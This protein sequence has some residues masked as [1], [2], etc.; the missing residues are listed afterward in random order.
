MERAS[1]II[2]TVCAASKSGFAQ[3][4]ADSDSPVGAY[5][6]IQVSVVVPT[7]GRA[8]LLNRCLEALT[9]QHFEPTAYEIIIVDDG[10][11]QDT[12]NIVA[13]WTART[14]QKRLD[15]FYIANHGPH[16]PA[17]ARNRG[18]RAARAPIIAFTDDDTVPTA[19]WLKNGLAQFAHDVD[20]ISGR[21][22]MPVSGT[23]TDYERD[24]QHLETAEFVTANCFCRKNVLESVG[25][26]D[27]RFRYAWREDSDFHFR[28]LEM[29]ANIVCA[30]QAVIVHPVRPA[31]WGVSISQ[32]KKILFDALLYKKHPRLYREKIRA[33][34]RWDYYLIVASL[35]AGLAALA[36]GAFGM[37]AIAGGIWLLMTARFCWS[38]LRNTAKTRSH[39]GE[40]LVTSVLIPPLAV[41]WRMVGALRFRVPLI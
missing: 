10:P 27:E 36:L 14:S 38:R 25:G 4:T 23:P 39:I 6:C 41:F 32:Q 9:V 20:V 40:M 35:L 3:Q 28:L 18:W 30:P 17:A 21:I 11:S 2:G 1:S 37:A 24:A 34:P 7:C 13:E 29:R 16:G 19:D 8:D 12:E 26:F 33:T 5:S 22:E 15:I 31:P